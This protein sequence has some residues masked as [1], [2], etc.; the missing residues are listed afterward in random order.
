MISISCQHSEP[1]KRVEHLHVLI[2]VGE[3]SYRNIC[4][5][6]SGM[7]S[8]TGIYLGDNLFNSR[9]EGHVSKD[10]DMAPSLINLRVMTNY[11]IKIATS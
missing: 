2:F 11:F 6:D 7:A 3:I 8:A 5:L 1:L 9:I 10:L 4:R